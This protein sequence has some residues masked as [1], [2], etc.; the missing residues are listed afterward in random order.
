MSEAVL[1]SLG[2]LLVTTAVCLW[3]WRDML[4][5][6]SRQARTSLERRVDRWQG[7][8]QVPLDDQPAWLIA[9]LARRLAGDPP[10]A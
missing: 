1:I 4:R 2:F 6:G 9:D 5:S 8:D 10:T 3:L 7:A